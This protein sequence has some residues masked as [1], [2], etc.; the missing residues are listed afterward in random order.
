MRT[1]E[2]IQRLGNDLPPVRPLARPWKRAAAWIACGTAY[3]AAVVFS[4]WMR[5]RPLAMSA[6]DAALVVQQLALMATGATASI[7]AFVSVIPGADR[8]LLAAPAV[9]GIVLIATMLWDC[10]ADARF[11]GTLGIGSE[12]DWPCVVS[13]AV[14]GVTLWT[15]ALAMLRRGAPLSPSIT[16]LLAGIAVLSIANIEACLTRPHQF[17]MTI[18]LWHGV[19]TA[20]L[21]GLL[22][23]VGPGLLRWRTSTS[24]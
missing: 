4:V 20:L 17:A 9:P 3:I 11:F 24:T 2:L 5:G 14:G 12:T 23:V 6:A 15:V 1:E 19:T 21:I 13:I 8:R 7:A 18:L 16:S 10:V 22:L